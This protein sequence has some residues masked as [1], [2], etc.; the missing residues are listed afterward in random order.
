VSVLV[1]SNCLDNFGLQAHFQ[2]NS[3]ETLNT[4]IPEN[5]VSFL[6]VDRTQD[7]DIR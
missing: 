7:F 6:T 2:T 5:F 1:R 4:K 3:G